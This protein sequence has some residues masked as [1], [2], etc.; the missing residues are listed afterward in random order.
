MTG[1]A[2]LFEGDMG[3]FQQVSGPFDLPRLG[4][5]TAGDWM[6]PKTSIK[7]VPAEYH[8]Q[9]AIAAAFE[10][11]PRIGDPARIRSI[12]IATFR[13]A[14]EIIGQDPEKW[15]PKTRETA[16]HSLPYCTAVALVDGEVSAAQFTPDRLADPALL[17]LVA[18]TTVV[19]DP[20]LTAGYPAGI[21]NRVSVT[22]DDGTVLVEEVAFP[23]GH[24][25]N[26]LTDDQ[27]AVKFHGL[28][29]PALGADRAARLCDR[30]A[31]ARRRPPAAR[32]H[33]P[34]RLARIVDPA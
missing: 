4:G 18:R 27:L 5:P 26:P 14:V 6:L 2:P 3:F 13:T 31:R 24:D 22:L 32:G 23:P 17:D 12:E 7:F 21:P 30:L 11:R 19:E 25:K 1:P 34:A 8:S 33:R 9:S 16:D 10:L 15:R 29:D 20:A 28:A